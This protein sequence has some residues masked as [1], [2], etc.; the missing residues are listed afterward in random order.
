M[1]ILVSDRYAVSAN[2]ASSGVGI[3]KEI[4]VSEHL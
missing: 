4:M 2:T 3:G 1:D